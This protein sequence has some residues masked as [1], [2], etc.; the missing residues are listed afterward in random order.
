MPVFSNVPID[1]RETSVSTCDVDI[2]VPQ[3][4]SVRK[5]TAHVESDEADAE[6][7]GFFGF[8]F[9]FVMQPLI[10]NYN[11]R[12]ITLSTPRWRL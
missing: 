4:E 12:L 6:A 9:F 3:D 5:P 1:Q 10:F 8:F 7:L 2:F 11:S